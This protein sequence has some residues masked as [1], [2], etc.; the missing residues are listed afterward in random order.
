MKK[1]DLIS[2]LIGILSCT[3]VFI[4]IGAIGSKSIDLFIINRGGGW[5]AYYAFDSRNGD[6]YK[7]LVSK[8]SDGKQY[9]IDYTKKIINLHDEIRKHVDDD[10]ITTKGIEEID[11]K[12]YTKNELI[13]VLK[14]KSG[15]EVK[16]LLG[17]PSFSGPTS[18]WFDITG[19]AHSSYDWGG[20]MKAMEWRYS[21]NSRIL[22]NET[23]EKYIGF[24][25]YFFI[26][27]KVYGIK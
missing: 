4:F 17:P 11:Q 9:T 2:M 22:W 6:L 1:R 7:T 19:K 24:S 27:D 20:D 10:P 25:V 18:S 16:T 14:G 13:N 15:A 5:E 8:S 26:E 12:I 23:T 21:S 3:I